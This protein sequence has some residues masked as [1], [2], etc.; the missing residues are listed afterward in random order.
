MNYYS[1]QIFALASECDLPV[2]PEQQWPVPDDAF[3]SFKVRYLE[4]SRKRDDHLNAYLSTS[5]KLFR[6]YLPYT[7]RVFLMASQIVWYLDEIIIRDPLGVIMDRSNGEIER[8]KI[9]TIQL[10]QSLSRFRSYLSDGYILLAGHQTFKSRKIDNYSDIAGS[11]L[12]LPVIREAL[13]QSTY[14]GYTSR[15]DSEG[16]DTDI[17]QLQLDSSGILGWGAM[18][19]VAGKSVTTPAIRFGEILP[20]VTLEYLER[21]VRLDFRQMMRASY[22]TE[23]KRTLALVDTASDLRAA[24]IFD[25]QL[26]QLI[27]DNAGVKLSDQKQVATCGI[28]NFSLPFVT[29]IPAERM[30]DIREK[31]PMVFIDFRAKLLDIVNEC[32]KSGVDASEE[33]KRRVQEQLAPNLTVIDSEIEASLKKARILSLGCPLVSGA[34]ILTGALL[35][36]P[37]AALIGIGAAGA[38]AAVKAFA[39][40]QE[41]KEKVKG[42]P[43]YFLWRV[44]Q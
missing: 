24:I 8:D 33:I 12:E 3:S 27:L 14:Y 23:I 20:A 22:L 10:L 6:V 42:H 44:K 2:R 16:R 9:E 5:S 13:E 19:G 15:K 30:C 32:L 18:S 7:A 34:A 36:A 39:D 43:F 35:S 4:W 26:D 29:G 1:D 41:T 40:D 17:Y 31:M 11:L 25:R 28:L 21:I 37:I 38:L